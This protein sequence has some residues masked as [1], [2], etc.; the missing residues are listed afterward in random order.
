MQNAAIAHVGIDAHYDRLSVSA[1][2]LPAALERL[3]RES[4]AGNVTIP[5]KEAVARA[6]RCTP[7][8]ARVGAVNTFWHVDGILIGHNTDVAGALAVIDRLQPS[9]LVNGRTTIL[10]AGGAAAAALLAVAQRG[11]HDIVMWSRSRARAEE[12][13]SRVGIQTTTTGNA[14]DA[15]AGA[16]LVINAT[17]IGLHDDRVPVPVSSLTR[18]AAVF[19]LVYRTGETAWVRASR[20]AGHE[21]LDGLPML[22]EQGACAFECWFGVPAPRDIMRHAL[23][24]ESGQ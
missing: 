20:A 15:V 23:L 17:P 18:G 22:L 19:D 8:A 6:A 21:A 24:R 1:S 10:G 5:H 2:D 13:S 16:D 7:L 9:G 3:A 12:L 14:E 11:A 4:M